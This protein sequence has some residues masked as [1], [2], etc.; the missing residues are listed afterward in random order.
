MINPHNV[1]ML[2]DDDKIVTVD[3]VE[4]L[5]ITVDIQSCAKVC[6]SHYQL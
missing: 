3:S 4:D 5:G 6:E 2:L 1:D